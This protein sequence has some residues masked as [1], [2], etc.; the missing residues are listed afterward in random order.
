M[1]TNLANELG[2]HLVLYVIYIKYSRYHENRS[3]NLI[4]IDIYIYW[5]YYYEIVSYIINSEI[6]II[7]YHNII[8]ISHHIYIYICICIYIYVYI[9]YIHDIYI[10]DIYIWLSMYI[11][12]IYIYICDIYIWYI[13]IYDYLC[14]YICNIIMVRFCKNSPISSQNQWTRWLFFAPTWPLLIALPRGWILASMIF[15]FCS[16]ATDWMNNP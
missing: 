1:F 12:D 10:Y 16:P 15:K 2:H 13:Y 14:I 3:I 4:V 11:Y 8:V 5:Y 7:V 9:I 6:I